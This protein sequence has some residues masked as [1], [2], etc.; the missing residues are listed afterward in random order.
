MWEGGVNVLYVLD[1]LWW[2]LNSKGAWVKWNNLRVRGPFPRKWL[3][4][5]NNKKC[6][7]LTGNWLPFCIL[8]ILL[9]VVVKQGYIS[10]WTSCRIYTTG[11]KWRTCWTEIITAFKRDGSHEKSLFNPLKGKKAD[12]Q[13]LIS[14]WK[15]IV[16][17]VMNR[18]NVYTAR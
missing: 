8:K 11:F 15:G 12:I 1:P 13:N 6:I 10:L 9:F 14:E 4:T 16:S 3:K 7:F 2:W 18:R 5:V 17:T